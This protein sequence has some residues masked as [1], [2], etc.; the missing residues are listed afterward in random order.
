MRA[1]KKLLLQELKNKVEGASSVI[2]ARYHGLNSLDTAD[3]RNQIAEN[4]G[5]FEVVR[6]RVL[7]KAAEA[8]GIELA[9][10]ELPGHIGV[11]LAHDDAVELTKSI[12]KFRKGRED[13]LE[14]LGGVLDNKKVN[15]EE[16]E[17]L[18]NLPSLRDLRAQFLGL[19]E[20]PMAQ[21]V[22]TMEAILT[23]IIHCMEN[24]STKEE[25]N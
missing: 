17:L 21:T 15:A 24:K 3:F 20:A 25:S 23:S 18:S 13:S 7:I 2:V 10:G 16:M 22:A 9:L 19:V 6:K 8:C 11:V 4:G 5:D 12:Y 14:V 1:E